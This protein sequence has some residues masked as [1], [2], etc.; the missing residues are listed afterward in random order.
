MRLVLSIVEAGLIGEPRERVCKEL[1]VHITLDGGLESVNKPTR[2][3][4][5]QATCTIARCTLPNCMH[6]R[7][8]LVGKSTKADAWKK[9]IQIA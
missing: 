9:T 4:T 6:Q 5:I 1:R 8:H 2:V 7:T 3:I